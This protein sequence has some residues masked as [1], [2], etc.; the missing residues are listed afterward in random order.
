MSILVSLVRGIVS[1][2]PITTSSQSGRFHHVFHALRRTYQLRD[3]DKRHGCCQSSPPCMSTEAPD[4]VTGCRPGC[5][6]PCRQRSLTTCVSPSVQKSTSLGAARPADPR[7]AIAPKPATAKRVV[8]KIVRDGPKKHDRPLRPSFTRE[9]VAKACADQIAR[10]GSRAMF[11][12]GTY[13]SPRWAAACHPFNRLSSHFSP[14]FL[15]WQKCR[16]QPQ[17]CSRG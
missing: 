17:V 12:P 10:G 14:S 3:Q 8:R 5:G 7:W 13:H 11:T 16:F 6:P 2:L 9:G 15:P 1:L 4:P